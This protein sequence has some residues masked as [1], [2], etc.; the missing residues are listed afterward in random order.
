MMQTFAFKVIVRPQ[1][2]PAGF[3]AW[4][5]E[6]R[7]PSESVARGY[8]RGQCAVKGWVIQSAERVL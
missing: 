2:A 1:D 6:V 3:P 4:R 7:A 8:L 5:Y